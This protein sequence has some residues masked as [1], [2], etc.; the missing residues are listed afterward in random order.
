MRLITRQ[1]KGSKLTIQEMDGNL[2][3]LQGI[4]QSGNHF[5]ST[6]QSILTQFSNNYIGWR[7]RNNDAIMQSV[8]IS[9]TA[10]QVI[11]GSISTEFGIGL[12]APGAFISIGDTIT[13]SNSSIAG[14]NGVWEVIG[15]LRDEAAA[16]NVTVKQ[17]VDKKLT[18]E[19]APEPSNITCTYQKRVIVTLDSI[20]AQLKDGTLIWE[21]SDNN[22]WDNED[23]TGYWVVTKPNYGTGKY[24]VLSTLQMSENFWDYGYSYTVK[25]EGDPNSVILTSLLDNQWGSEV[26]VGSGVFKLTLINGVLSLQETVY[27]LEQTWGELYEELTGLPSDELTFTFANPLWNSDNDWYGMMYGAQMGWYWMWTSDAARYFVGYNMLTGETQLIDISTSI[28]DIKN[29]NYVISA[30]P[31]KTL[32]SALASIQGVFSHP[33]YGLL[34]NM[35]SDRIIEDQPTAL[36]SP[37]YTNIEYATILDMYN[38]S[39]SLIFINGVLNSFDIRWS[40]NVDYIITAQPYE[41]DNGISFVRK[42]LD[43]LNAESEY[44][45]L[46]SYF[47]PTLYQYSSLYTWD[48]ENSFIVSFPTVSSTGYTL[49]NDHFFVWRNDKSLPE[50]IKSPNMYASVIEDD[51]L[52]GWYNPMTYSKLAVMTNSYNENTF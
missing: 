48:R 15:V 30:D 11:V 17:T 27:D 33:T 44:E 38:N 46:T 1:G 29:I 21:A 19:L 22:N 28:L 16:L 10:E 7:D 4:G 52:I 37:N 31:D 26:N 8:E 35:E 36:W 41:T 3:Y 5:Q 50:F 51:K 14:N 42:K 49:Q 12:N 47:N 43:D 32:G 18:D 20:H 34:L 6:S 25:V 45:T 13:I 9:S 40:L 23:I 2:E 39:Q 24:E